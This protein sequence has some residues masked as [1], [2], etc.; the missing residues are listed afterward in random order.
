M[1]KAFQLKEVQVVRAHVLKLVF[2]DGVEHLADF[3]PYFRDWSTPQEKRFSKAELFHKFKLVGHH[4]L[5]WGD[6]ALVF[7]AERLR[8]WESRGV[9]PAKEKAVA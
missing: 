9:V 8:K 1:N 5:E 4:A 6:A 3:G 7:S 2:G